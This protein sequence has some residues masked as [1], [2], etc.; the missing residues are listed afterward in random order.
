MSLYVLTRF[1]DICGWEAWTLPLWKSKLTSGWHNKV[2]DDFTDTIFWAMSMV[3]TVSGSLF[4]TLNYCKR[5]RCPTFFK[6]PYKQ[7]NCFL[8]GAGCIFVIIN[9]FIIA[10]W[11]KELYHGTFLLAWLAA[12]I[13]PPNQKKSSLYW[14]HLI[15]GLFLTKSKI[16]KTTKFGSSKSNKIPEMVDSPHL[17]DWPDWCWPIGSGE[18]EL[19]HVKVGLFNKELQKDLLGATR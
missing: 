11:M 3:L 7:P 1:F 6:K 12:E 18:N 16:K 17:P 8:G 19:H 14:M 2:S 13:N 4:D 10:V 5:L 9:L 15:K